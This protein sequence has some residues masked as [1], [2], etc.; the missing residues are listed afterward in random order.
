MSFIHYAS[1]EIQS[2]M[3]AEILDLSR[4]FRVLLLSECESTPYSVADILREARRRGTQLVLR[5]FLPSEFPGVA[6]H[7]IGVR[8]DGVDLD[9]VSSDVELCVH[10]YH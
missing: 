2:H 5:S 7:K 1:A 6:F 10:V 3:N 4:A 9:I 8:L